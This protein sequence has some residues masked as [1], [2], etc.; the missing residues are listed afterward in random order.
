MRE[1]Q[2]SLRRQEELVSQK[3]EATGKL[4]D[5]VA[6]LAKELDES[7]CAYQA[8][9]ARTRGV[10]DR[11]ETDRDRIAKELACARAEAD[12]VRDRAAQ[13]VAEVS[14]DCSWRG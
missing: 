8:Q 4:Q 5:R 13:Q 12:E 7:R 10:L 3:N 1:L 9:E 2:R 14:R 11:L 6:Q